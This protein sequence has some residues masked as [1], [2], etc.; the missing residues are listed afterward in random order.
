[1]KSALTYKVEE[2]G[3]QI[4]FTDSVRLQWRSTVNIFQ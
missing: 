4:D 1:M 2:T 3:T